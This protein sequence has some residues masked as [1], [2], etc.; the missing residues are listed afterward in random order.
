VERQKLLEK[1][2][3]EVQKKF[4]FE[5][6]RFSEPIKKNTNYCERLDRLISGVQAGHGE[7]KRE[8][9]RLKTWASEVMDVRREDTKYGTRN[10]D[11]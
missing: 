10:T 4:D 2:H 9:A 11:N 6:S 8:I 1:V 3:I 5:E 7:H